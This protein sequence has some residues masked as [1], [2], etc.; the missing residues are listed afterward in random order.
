[1]L[2]SLYEQK[3]KQKYNFLNV[4]EILFFFFI[5]ILFISGA[6][7]YHENFSQIIMAQRN[8]NEIKSHIARKIKPWQ[9][10]IYKN[11]TDYYNSESYGD[12]I[13]QKL[14][15]TSVTILAYHNVREFKQSDSFIAR[16]MYITTPDIF[17]SEMAYLRDNDYHVISMDD[18]MESLH[19][20]RS[21]ATNSVIITFDDGYKSQHDN[22]LPILE[23][24]NMTAIFFI[25]TKAIS[26]YKI[27][28]TWDD[29]NDLVAHDMTIGGHS[30]S[31]PK[32]NKISDQDELEME[33]KNSKDTIEKHIGIPI[34]YFAYPYGLYNRRV[35][36][37]VKDAGYVAALVDNGS[38]TRIVYR[39]YEINRY[40][41]GNDFENFKKVVK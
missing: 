30:Y 15:T 41:I 10:V 29:V 40:N 23:R 24:Y 13:N 20:M 19:G 12:D 8:Y 28:M 18:L 17:S 2:M 16:E 39:P 36:Q 35:I 34:Y 25:Y 5:I 1:M 26:T 27:S 32:L 6:M 33:I 37:E 14:S 9:K 4:R 22:A 38:N 7:Y 3:N 31:H 11:N 21:I